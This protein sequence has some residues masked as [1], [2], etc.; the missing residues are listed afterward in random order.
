MGDK[1]S[2]SKPTQLRG[3]PARVR[4]QTLASARPGGRLGQTLAC[5]LTLAGMLAGGNASATLPTGGEIVSGSGSISQSGTQLTV[6]QQSDRLVA[7]WSSFSIGEGHRVDFIQPDRS[8]A[9][10][11]RVTGSD[12][13]RIQGSLTAN[14]QVFLVNPNGIVFTP[15]AHVDVGGLV[16]STLALDAEAFMRGGAR[17]AF[18]GESGHAVINQ[19]RVRAADGT[20]AMVAAR[21]INTGVIET[22]GGATLLA[23]GRRVVLDL[24]GPVRIEVQE[25]ALDALIEQGGAIQADGGVVYLSARS[26]NAL[27]STVINHTGVTEARTLSAGER[28]EIVLS[29]D[30]DVGEV[31]LAGRLDVSGDAARGGR[32]V[33]EGR[34]IRLTDGARIDA[35]GGSGGGDVLI[36]GDWQG[37]ANAERRVFAAP[38]AVA[39]ARTVT[40]AAGAAIDAS[41]IERGD[42]GTIVLWSAITDPAAVT[43]VAGRLRAEGGARGG[44]GGW[45]ET[46]GASLRL[47]EISVSTLAPQ[48]R[49]GEW[50]LDPYDITITTAAANTGVGGFAAESDSAVISA[51]LLQEALASNNITVSTG[52][53]GE[54][55]GNITVD[56]DIVWSANTFLTLNAAN[57]IVVNARIENTN[58]VR[59]GV[60][61]AAKDQRDA[62]TFGDNGVV[63]IHNLEQLDRVRTALRGTYRLGSDI[64]A[65]ATMSMNN[66]QGWEPIGVDLNMSFRGVFD[67]RN[68]T[69]SNLYIERGSSDQG[70]FGV[71][72]DAVIKNIRLTDVDVSAGTNVGG[73]IGTQDGGEVSGVFV[74]GKV[75]GSRRIG[76]LVGKA[77]QS[78]IIVDSHSAVDVLVGSDDYGGGLVG[79][80]QQETTVSRSFA[81]GDVGIISD[82][83]KYVGGLVGRAN[84]STISESYATGSV[85]GVES[86]GGLV[87]FSEESNISESY[88]TGSVVGV[89]SVGGLVGR[90]RYS[91]TFV[92]VYATGNVSAVDQEINNDFLR[93]GGL[94][95][96]IHDIYNS[97]SSGDYMTITN[98]Y[99]LGEVTPVKPE[100]RVGAFVGES[101]PNVVYD[102]VFWNTTANPGLLGVGRSESDPDGMRGLPVGELQLLSTFLAAGWDIGLVETTDPNASP[103]PVLSMSDDGPIW[104]LL[105]VV[106]PEVP[107]APAAPVAGPVLP[108]P[109]V[110]GEPPVAD[111]TPRTPVQD[112]VQLDALQDA[113][114]ADSPLRQAGWLL[115]GR[116]N[117]PGFQRVF[118]VGDGV[119]LPGGDDP[120]GDADESR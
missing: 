50:L 46:S 57:N 69:I 45:I 59:G 104:Q 24:G 17:H 96:R 4:R 41:A 81:T 22:P 99:A 64:D 42:G 95:G 77:E 83:G 100:Q 14:G 111:G 23:A 89:E 29:G 31:V 82:S 103:F 21:V 54:Q 73:L 79:L 60:V 68:R 117:A 27:V 47:G 86:V 108:L 55:E 66:G 97:D 52:S 6:T 110:D 18:S 88:A 113:V 25:G 67:G 94:V 44:D 115:G 116:L 9:A 15:S 76:G 98:A 109:P 40:M 35:R 85:V 84:Y 53:G 80:I 5:A 101:H 20:V 10:L 36:G 26:A 112:Q 58:T 62:V 78:A 19:G 51:Q 39:E 16:A 87:G 71:T 7:D 1:R 74:S 38:D 56:A 49:T 48:G 90:V 75:Q 65:S 118:V 28:G 34:D 102:G 33:I 107:A 12:V 70:L 3:R 114:A 13:S 2:M 8:A 92:N 106:E 32:V 93:L 105:V 30:A 120:E 43:T 11:N 91:G 61:F 119:R 72:Q 37:G 63:V